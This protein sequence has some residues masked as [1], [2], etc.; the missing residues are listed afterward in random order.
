MLQVLFSGWENADVLKCRFYIRSVWWDRLIRRQLLSKWLFASQFPKGRLCLSSHPEACEHKIPTRT[1]TEGCSPCYTHS[2]RAGHIMWLRQLLKTHGWGAS[3]HSLGFERP[4]PI[5]EWT[6]GH[7]SHIL[8][9]QCCRD[10]SSSKLTDSLIRGTRV[11]VRPLQ[12][13]FHHRQRIAVWG[14]LFFWMN[15][16][17][18][19]IASGLM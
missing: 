2:P 5:L 9:E 15:R 7:L 19:F 4:A 1:Q 11:K 6:L 8:G 16:K 12:C 18:F 3:N 13:Q 14:A 10:G 17:Y